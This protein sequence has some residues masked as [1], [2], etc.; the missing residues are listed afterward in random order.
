[1]KLS[2]SIQFLTSTEAHRQAV[3][4]ERVGLREPAGKAYMG[5]YRPHVKQQLYCGDGALPAGHIKATAPQC[6]ARGF[7]LGSL[8]K[9]RQLKRERASSAKPAQGTKQPT[10]PKQ[11]KAPTLPIKK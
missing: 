2:L 1:M 3:G 6:M 7:G 5:G 9:A 11:T 8:E 10:Q 4:V